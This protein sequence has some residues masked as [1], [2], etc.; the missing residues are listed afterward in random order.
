MP[1]KTT[2]TWVLIAIVSLLGTGCGPSPRELSDAQ[3]LDLQTDMQQ[4][5]TEVGRQRDQLEAD[6]RQWDQRERTEPVLAA[7]VVSA[8]MLIACGLPLI[9]VGI[10]FWPR[11]EPPASDAMCEVLIDEVVL[12]ISEPKRIVS[13]S[14]PPK[15]ASGK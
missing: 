6:R 3:W 7:A 8:A 10:L 11:K 1:T 4:E 13:S 14:D 15:L 9:V 2:S 12:H 5:R